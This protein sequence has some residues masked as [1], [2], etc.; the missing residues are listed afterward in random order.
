[1][2]SNLT[3]LAAVAVLALGLAVWVGVS[4]TPTTTAMSTAQPLVAGLKDGLN[5]VK[6]V[7]IVGAESKPIVTLAK[8][9]AGWTV[10]EKD[11]YP[12]DVAKVRE[13]L[14]RL[15]DAKLIEPKTS[16][17]A[18]Y[19]KLGV[20]DV[21]KPE[22]DG[23]LVEIDG[24]AKPARVIVGHYNGRAG[25][26]T[27]VRLADDKQSYLAKG[28]L[29]VDKTTANWLRRDLVDVSTARIDQVTITTAGKT[30]RAY[31]N[32]ADDANYQ[33]ADVPKG[34]ELDSEF[35]ANGLASVLAGLR[36][37]D[38]LKA[39][40]A[41]PPEASHAVKYTTFEGLAVDATAWE[42][43]GKD[44]AR[45]VAS[46]DAAKAKAYIAADQ[47]KL[48]AQLEAQ[49]AEAAAQ[50]PVADAAAG[51]ANGATAGVA[52]DAATA[53]SAP[54]VAA[55]PPAPPAVADPAKD[56]ADRLAALHREADAL[57]ARFE[58][59]TYV[60]P[61]Y[62]FDNMKKSLDDLLKPLAAKK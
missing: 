39:D 3:K 34:R 46:V 42:A 14:M 2:N 8:S 9:E 52:A 35:I 38:V 25:D 57:N 60:I 49:K 51:G 23:A 50:Q 29:A 62:K 12:A 11:G 45:F 17:E 28:N 15:A 36:F 47:A 61:S 6:Q 18:S 59:W 13:M 10:A 56:E 40:A 19:G 41:T 58:G 32:T 48:K 31:K 53:A 55:E 7:R 16:V 54:P 33:V 20:E 27:F 4:R 30:V 37:E 26:G 24:L 22:S 43:D 44:Y 1:M 5:E 21:A